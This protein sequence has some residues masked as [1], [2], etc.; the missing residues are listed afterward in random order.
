MFDE[1]NITKSG[2]NWGRS[3]SSGIMWFLFRVEEVYLQRKKSF[4]S[5]QCCIFAF[6]RQNKSLKYL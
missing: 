6:L 5:V 1:S 4:G 2:F 3:Q